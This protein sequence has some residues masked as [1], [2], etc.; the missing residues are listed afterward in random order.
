M[1]FGARSEDRISHWSLVR[2]AL[3][4]CG[5]LVVLG[6]PPVSATSWYGSN[7]ETGS[8]TFLALTLGVGIVSVARWVLAIPALRSLHGAGVRPR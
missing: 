5:V 4:A 7:G 1:C 8:Q 3:L 6:H 2:I